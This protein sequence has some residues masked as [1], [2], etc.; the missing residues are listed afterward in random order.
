[1]TTFQIRYI[2]HRAFFA[3]FQAIYALFIVKILYIIKLREIYFM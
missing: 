3:M 1:M 2:N